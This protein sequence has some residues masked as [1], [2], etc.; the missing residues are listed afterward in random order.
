MPIL[1]I[2]TINFNNAIGLEKTINSVAI[3]TFNDYEYIIID[4]GSSDESV[5]VIKKYS[6]VNNW[7]SEKDNGIYDAMNKGILKAQGEYLLFLNS[8]DFLIDSKSLENVFSMNYSQDIIYGDMKINWGNNH[9]TIGH[10]PK[11]ITLEHMI[12][13]TVWHPVSFIKKELFEKWGL[14][15]TDYKIVADYEFFFRTIIAKNATTF[16]CEIP[17]T[18]YNVEGVSSLPA[19]KQRELEE[20][21]LVLKSYLSEEEI[22]SYSYLLTQKK[23]SRLIKWFKRLIK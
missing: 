13:D 8:G 11:K 17:I 10:M 14:Y 23:E 2:I 12:K 18:E 1:S 21:L 7:V 15:N 9:S 20:R 3:Q 16:H 6:R 4:G 22:K 19:N 5:N